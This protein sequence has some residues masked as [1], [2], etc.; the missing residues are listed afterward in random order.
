M[1]TCQKCG[2]INLKYNPEVKECPECNNKYTD[3]YSQFVET[4]SSASTGQKVLWGHR[5]PTGSLRIDED[6]YS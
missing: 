2:H 3:E 5:E 4:R 1:K 6:K